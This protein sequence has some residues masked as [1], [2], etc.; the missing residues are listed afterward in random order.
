MTSRS[1]SSHQ[2]EWYHPRTFIVHDIIS[3]AIP[4]MPS[5]IWAIGDKYFGSVDGFA[6]IEETGQP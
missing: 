3:M 2:E 6:T 1:S 4:F 5:K